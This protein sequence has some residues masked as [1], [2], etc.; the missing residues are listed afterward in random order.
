MKRL[1]EY[2][3]HGNVRE[4]KHFIERAVILSQGTS[5]NLPSFMPLNKKKEDSGEHMTM[6]EMERHHI[7]KT[8]NQCG[9]QV[10][11]EVGAAKLL[12]LNPQ[13]LYSKMRKLGIQ[14]NSFTRKQ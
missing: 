2:P 14:K 5:L 8:L 1:V 11:G 10:S 6:T 3:W 13:T 12:D 9:W 7:I 4:L